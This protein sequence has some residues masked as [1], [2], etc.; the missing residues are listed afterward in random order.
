MQISSRSFLATAFLALVPVVQSVSLA[1]EM[2]SFATG[3]YAAG[4]R[5]MEMMH[6][7]D[8]NKD[9]KVSK[10][11]WIAFQARVFTSLDKDKTGFLETGEFYGTPSDDVAFATAAFS[12]G[13]RTKEMFTKL[14]ANGDGK[15]SRNEFMNYQIMIFE[16]MDKGKKQELSVTD[17]IVPA[18]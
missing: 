12:R 15:V 4:L 13:L 9:G 6:M 14:D 18:H 3:G 11:E 16:T 17:F 8:T 5:T 7:I 10:D 1:D 2:A